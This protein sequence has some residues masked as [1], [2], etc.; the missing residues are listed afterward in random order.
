MFICKKTLILEVSSSYVWWYTYRRKGLRTT[1]P[2]STEIST[3]LRS[4][5]KSPLYLEYGGGIGVLPGGGGSRLS[6]EPPRT[7]VVFRCTRIR[8]NRKEHETSTIRSV[9]VSPIAIESNVGCILRFVPYR[10]FVTKNV[11]Y[12]NLTWRW[13]VVSRKKS[14][15][16]VRC[17]KTT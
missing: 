5:W 3:A 4:K 13:R 8:E 6:C 16:L 1:T 15:E 17:Y 2:Y 12:D 10:G 7:V 11:A 14:W 9:S